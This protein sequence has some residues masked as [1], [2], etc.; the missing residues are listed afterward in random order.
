M[1]L[2]PGKQLVV[3]GLV[4]M[5]ECD[6]MNFTLASLVDLNKTLFALLIIYMWE[7]DLR[8]GVKPTEQSVVG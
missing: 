5:R 3:I 8:D 4:V 6:L 2:L 7:I 1:T